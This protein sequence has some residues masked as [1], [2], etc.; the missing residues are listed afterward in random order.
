MERD[1][2]E[3]IWLEVGVVGIRRAGGGGGGGYAGFGA[4]AQFSSVAA[5][6]RLERRN[7]YG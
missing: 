4:D 5:R 1:V 6:Y 2:E 3:V 7:I